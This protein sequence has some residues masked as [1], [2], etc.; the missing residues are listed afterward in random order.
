MESLVVDWIFLSMSVLRPIGIVKPQKCV[1]LRLSPCCG[2]RLGHLWSN[3][4]C[5]PTSSSHNG[6]GGWR[7][8]SRV[9][10]REWKTREGTHSGGG[11]SQGW[12]PGLRKYLE[13]WILGGTGC[14]EL[15]VFRVVATRGTVPHYSILLDLSLH[16]QLKSLIWSKTSKTKNNFFR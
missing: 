2:R 9:V 12:L 16:P 13:Q 10:N 8:L 6:H 7:S 15:L 14:F 11:S 3:P 5:T 1:C 4:C